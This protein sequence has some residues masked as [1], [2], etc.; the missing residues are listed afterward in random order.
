MLEILLIIQL[1]QQ[2][3]ILTA[4]IKPCIWPNKCEAPVVAQIHPCVWP[5]RCEAPVVAQ[6]RPCVWPN[7]CEN[8]DAFRL[9]ILPAN[10]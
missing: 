7:K 2:A 3:P 1:S 10:S 8:P 9:D 4:E 6:I 5:N